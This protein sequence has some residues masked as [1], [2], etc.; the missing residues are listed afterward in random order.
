[1]NDLVRTLM[2]S[3]PINQVIVENGGLSIDTLIQNIELCMP[4]DRI[5]IQTDD[6]IVHPIRSITYSNELESFVLVIDD[7]NVLERIDK[8]K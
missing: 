7:R 5:G 3:L 6:G 1:M 2:K 8:D 4:T